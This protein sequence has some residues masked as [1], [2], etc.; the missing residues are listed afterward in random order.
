MSFLD[1]LIILFTYLIT[2]QLA[3]AIVPKHSVF[4]HLLWHF[5]QPFQF[6]ETC[7]QRVCRHAAC[8]A[9]THRRPLQSTWIITASFTQNKDP[10]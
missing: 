1:T 3:T 5:L 10:R 8:S 6:S 7:L 4:W 9:V 2:R